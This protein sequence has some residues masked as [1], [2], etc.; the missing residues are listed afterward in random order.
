MTFEKD[1]YEEEQDTGTGWRTA[2]ITWIWLVTSIDIWCSQ[3]L[4]LDQEMNPL[5]RMIMASGGIWAMVA[6]KVFGTFVATE[7]L[8]RLPT[9]FSVLVAILGAVLLLI[10]AGVIPV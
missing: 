6:C 10:L 7:W 9:Y 3:W 5:A 8:R 1:I 4:T 2:L